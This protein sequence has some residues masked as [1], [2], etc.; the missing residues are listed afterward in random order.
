M[1]DVGM[2]VAILNPFVKSA[3]NVLKTEL[4]ANVQRGAVRIEN[5]QRSTHDVNVLIGVIGQAYGTVYYGMSIETACQIVGKMMGQPFEE[6][7]DMAQSGI[8]ELGNVIT[9]LASKGLSEYGY[10][11]NITPPH[12][13][14]G[15]NVKINAG[16]LMRLALPLYSPCGEIEIHLALQGA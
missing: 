7:D 4:G 16:D 9:G 14:T 10:E 5:G 3:I 12:L 15:Q 11:C 1:A 13:I 2:S 6:F 8:A